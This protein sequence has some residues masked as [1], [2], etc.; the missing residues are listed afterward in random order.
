MNSIEARSELSAKWRGQ[1]D[2]Y[3]SRVAE[4]E[5]LSAREAVVYD[6]QR[7]D[8]ELLEPQK[9]IKVWKAS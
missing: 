6:E 2:Y 9:V 1:L 4:E 7:M 3:R 8:C 5:I